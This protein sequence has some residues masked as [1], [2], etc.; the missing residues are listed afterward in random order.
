MSDERKKKLEAIKKR[1]NEFQK[2]LNEQTSQTTQSNPAIPESSQNNPSSRLDTSASESSSAPPSKP[3]STNPSFRPLPIK[4]ISIQNEKIY[5]IKIKK[6]N[7]SLRTCK[8]EHHINGIPKDRKTEETQ[9]VL[10][11]EF[12][13]EIKQEELLIQ[14][15]E[16]AKRSSSIYAAKR[17]SV[18]QSTAKDKW[19]KV[20]LLQL[21]KNKLKEEIKNAEEKNKFY[22]N[23]E[24]NLK[25]YLENKF[26]LMNQ[27][28]SVNDIFDICNTYYN[29]EE[30]NIN[31]SKKTLATHLCDLYDDQSS[32]R[33]VTTLDWSPNQNDLFLAS[34]SGT[35]DFIQQSGLIQLWSLSNRKVPDYVINYQTEITSAVLLQNK[36]LH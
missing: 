32:G 5:S 17:S 27:A 24:T 18:V 29:E 6:I 28:L 2:L 15:N 30:S 16:K 20:K 23:N 21:T 36:S 31:V 7:Q 34:F 35:E 19:G 10:P 9:Y 3:I 33:I 8:S 25:N 14:Q 13:E 11:K 1:K 26:T 22:K 4:R 12:E